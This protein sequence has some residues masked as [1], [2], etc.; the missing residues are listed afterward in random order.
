MNITTV[1]ELNNYLKRSFDSNQVLSDIW[2]KGEISN[3]K[4]H[5]S[6]HMYF[7]LKDEAS[8]LKCVMFKSYASYMRFVPSDGMKVVCHGR[9]SVFERDGT[10][11]LYPDSMISDG[12]GDLY[13][14]YEKLKAKLEA[15]GL[16]DEKYKKALPLYPKKIGVVT[17]PTGAAIRDIINVITRRSK[18]AEILIFPVLVQGE[19]AKESIS[20]AIYNINKYK[21]CDVIITG[22]GGGSI[23]DLWPFNEEIVARAIFDSDIPVISAVGHETDFTISDFV[24]DMRAPTPSAAAELAV[25]D[26]KDI[27]ANIESAKRTIAALISKKIT[28]SKYSLKLITETPVFKDKTAFI[29]IR[30]EYIDDC[31]KLITDCAVKKKETSQFEFANLISRL[32]ALSPL[33]VLKRGYSSVE[34]NGIIIKNADDLKR[35]DIINI[36]FYNGEKQAKIME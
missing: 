7:T 3:F 25:R 28:Q 29:N 1:S 24:A 12:V 33:A 15:E 23:E 30:R 26:D 9:I 34:H 17:S 10:Y 16:F 21:M 14:A 6:G 4:L 31:L 8:A 2:I 35:D 5:F 18:S 13:V 32:E 19:G 20:E 36:R 22:R 11:Q 27:I